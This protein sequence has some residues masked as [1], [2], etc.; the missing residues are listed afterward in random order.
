MKKVLFINGHLNSGGVERSLVDILCHLDY[1]KYEVDL[2]LL[3]GTGD[4]LA[5]VPKEVHII[6]RDLHNT[7]GSLFSS[8][9]RCIRKKD[10][11]CLKMRLSFFLRKYLKEK[12][13]K[14]T[15]GILIGKHKYDIAVGFRPGICSELVAYS[16]NAD[17][18]VI[19]WHHGEFN[20]DAEA[21]NKL[22][23]KVDDVVA[24]SKCCCKMIADHCPE[25]VDKLI[26]IPNMIDRQ[27]LVNKCDFNP[28]EDEDIFRIVSV[29]RLSPEKHF[30]NAV[31]AAAAL[32]ENGIAFKWHFVGDGIERSNLE[33][34]V[35]KYGLENCAIFEGTQKN[36]YP[37]I[38]NAD[39]FAHPSYVESQG[40]SILEA[41]AFGIPSVVTE[42]SGALEYLVSGENAILT[43]QNPEDFAKKVLE[44]SV[45]RELYQRIKEGT[46]LPKQYSNGMV[47]ER[48]ENIFK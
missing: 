43:K 32:K 36:P 29:G 11:M 9:V 1:S 39:L 37:Y 46:I 10:Y 7:Y 5:E 31:H 42:S 41:L 22:C 34:L 44:I 19:W 16:V 13:L 38:K 21:Y 2:L 30:E 8:L 26:F 14:K 12:A 15:A 18:K 40:L 17:K 27:R 33:Q 6:E 45:D 35:R 48:I 20:V 25:A 47:M 24:V 28:Y 4:Y 3:E 23:S